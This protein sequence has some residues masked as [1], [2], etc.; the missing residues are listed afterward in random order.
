MHEP[1]T[2]RLGAPARGAY[3]GLF[4]TIGWNRTYRVTPDQLDDAVARSW[5]CVGAY[6]RDD[7]LVGAGRVVSDG[8]LYAVVFDVIVLPALQ[9]RGVG[10]RIVR[11]L[12]ERCDDARIRDVLLFAARGTEAFYRRLGFVPRAPDAP[13]MIR[14]RGA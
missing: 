7:R 8:L 2:L 6:H 14:R 4:E 1:V 13:G 12:L 10:T 5:A 3:F 11:A 9:R